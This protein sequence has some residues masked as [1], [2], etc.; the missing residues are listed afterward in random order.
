[1]WFR[2]SER[3]TLR[4]REYGSGISQALDF[5]SAA[6]C[7]LESSNTRCNLL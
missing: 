4:P 5:F 2:P 7:G 1:M 6:L 3:T